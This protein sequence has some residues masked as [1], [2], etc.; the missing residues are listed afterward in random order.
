MHSES[1]DSRSDCRINSRRYANA[2]RS[3]DMNQSAP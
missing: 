1:A 3:I 2:A